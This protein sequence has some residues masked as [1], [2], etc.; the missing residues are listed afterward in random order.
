MEHKLGEGSYGTVYASTLQTDQTKQYAV[1]VIP[2][3]I[4]KSSLHNS[5]MLKKEIEVLKKL[6]HENIVCLHEIS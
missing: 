3:T 2:A 1:K 6:R 4:F 5:E